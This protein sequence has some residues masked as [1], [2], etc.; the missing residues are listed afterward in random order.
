MNANKNTSNPQTTA[1]RLKRTK[2]LKITFNQRGMYVNV[3]TTIQEVLNVVL[4]GLLAV[5]VAQGTTPEAKTECYQMFN[6]A[7]SNFLAAYSPADY[8]PT[9]RELEQELAQE[10]AQL[11][12]KV[13][14]GMG[15]DIDLKWE[16]IDFEK[17]KEAQIPKIEEARKYAEEHPEELL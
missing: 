8:F 6:T 17:L 1:A 13:D 4:R 2:G 3:K 15:A 7:F 9:P 11:Q 14:L 5:A 16:N 12:A 10:A